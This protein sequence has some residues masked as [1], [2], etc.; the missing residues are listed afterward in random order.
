VLCDCPCTVTLPRI[1]VWDTP[2]HA[3]WSSALVALELPRLE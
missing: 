3:R 1:L 2:A